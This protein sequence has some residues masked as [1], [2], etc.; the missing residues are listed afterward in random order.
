MHVVADQNSKVLPL[1]Y[2]I[3][4]QIVHARIA[5]VLRSCSL[6]MQG[7]EKF[8]EMHHTYIYVNLCTLHSF[9][10]RMSIANACL[11]IPELTRASSGEE[12]SY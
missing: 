10:I 12:I 8:R 11:L 2:R 5:R 6:Q 3:P 7:T 9:Q 4:P 1:A